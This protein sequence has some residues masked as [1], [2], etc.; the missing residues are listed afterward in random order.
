[1]YNRSSLLSTI[2]GRPITPVEPFS[3]AFQG[4]T[5]PISTEEGGVKH[6]IHVTKH[7][8]LQS[9]V[10]QQP[11]LLEEREKFIQPSVQHSRQT[12]HTHLH[13]CIGLSH[14]LEN[15]PCQQDWSVVPHV[16]P[17]R[18]Q[19]VQFL[20]QFQTIAVESRGMNQKEKLKI[21]FTL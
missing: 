2:P 20:N 9:S 1:M 6:F 8:C 7:I 12:I 18:Y 19:T 3:R 10:A 4:T 16:A 14:K 5:H 17:F 15:G 11:G 13:L 21:Y